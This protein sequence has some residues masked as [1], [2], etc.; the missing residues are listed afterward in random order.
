MVVFEIGLLGCDPAMRKGHKL[1]MKCVDEI[2]PMASIN[3][4][5]EHMVKA[6]RSI[7]RDATIFTAETYSHIWHG[8]KTF[9]IW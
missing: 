1:E 2:N 5:L 3:R 7:H 9:S 8:G 6:L 4:K